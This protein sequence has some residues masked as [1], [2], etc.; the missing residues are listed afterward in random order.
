MRDELITYLK[1]KRLGTVTV[2]D[3][4]PFDKDGNSLYLKN[5]KRIY[6][7]KDSTVQS[8]V[9][10]TLD[11]GCIVEQ[12][13]TT[14]V[15]FTLDAKTSLVNYNDIISYL[16]EARNIDN[17]YHDRIVSINETY[18]GDAMVTEAIFSLKELIT[19]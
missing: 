16:R 10:N 13:S 3:E 18:Q 19:I 9:I 17:A 5:F 1:S 6:V 2:T 12:V 15:W 11:G 4:L 7:S 8:P 14:R